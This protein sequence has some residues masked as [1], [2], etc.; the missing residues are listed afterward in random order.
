MKVSIIVEMGTREITNLITAD[1]SAKHFIEEARSFLSD[2]EFEIFFVGCNIPP[3]GD[4]PSNCHQIDVCDTGYYGWKNIGAKAAR[5]RYLVFWDSDCRPKPGYL[6]QAVETLE[7]NP[8][9]SGL[10]GATL[11]EG[12]S[13]LTR[14]NTLLNFGYL[15]RDRETLGTYAPMGHNIV[16]RKQLF[17]ET[18]FGPHKA[19]AGGASHLAASAIQRGNPLKH[20]SSLQLFHE[21]ISYSLT[22][23]LEQH[24]R[25]IYIGLLGRANAPKITKIRVGLQALPIICL[26]RVWRLF[27]HRKTLQFSWLDTF[28][29]L[30]VLCGYAL[31]DFFVVMIITFFP[32]LLNRWT[33]YQFQETPSS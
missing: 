12:T 19:R 30:P 2:D 22:A 6:K 33:R 17:S 15:H 13:F 21:D 7:K 11:Y 18:P 31:L 16:I 24:L 29:A 10:T 25:E 5:G 1:T 8:S 20:M 32:S 23:L 26:K 4:L 27:Q 28:L 14:L 9:L 3:M